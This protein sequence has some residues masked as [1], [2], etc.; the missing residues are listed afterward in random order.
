MPVFFLYSADSWNSAINGQTYFP[1]Q[2]CF[3]LRERNSRMRE[4]G[5]DRASNESLVAFPEIRWEFPRD[6]I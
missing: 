4:S 2:L 1:S 6:S 3:P 5:I